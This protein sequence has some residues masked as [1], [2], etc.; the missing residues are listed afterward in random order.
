MKHQ[1]STIFLYLFLAIALSAFITKDHHLL[2]KSISAVSHPIDTIL[3]GNTMVGIGSK[4]MTDQNALVVYPPSDTKLSQ[5]NMYFT[6]VSTFNSDSSRLY[7]KSRRSWSC[8]PLGNANP[9]LPDQYTLGIT[10]NTK[11]KVGWNSYILD[12]PID[13]NVDTLFIWPDLIQQINPRISWAAN[14]SNNSISNL[15][16]TLCANP[17][18]SISILD[19]ACE[20][21][22]TKS[23]PCLPT[24]LITDADSSCYAADSI[25]AR[26]LIDGNKA[27][28]Y[29]SKDQV[30][31]DTTFEIRN[32]STLCIDMNACPD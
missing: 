18:T 30:I 7:V 13:I 1:Q 23:T 17:G 11:V 26:V 14:N 8:A 21:I 28:D 31:M 9:N 2:I 3:V 24:L 5:I 19:M 12:P 10:Q 29:L 22:F 16:G 6:S 27:I 4:I 25:L 32:N 15:T 20:L